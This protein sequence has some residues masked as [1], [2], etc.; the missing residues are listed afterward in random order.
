MKKAITDTNS[1]S[2]ESFYKI[3]IQDIIK[4]ETMFFN[5][6]VR[7]DLRHIDVFVTTLREVLEEIITLKIHERLSSK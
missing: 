1:W 6:E 4:I 5:T 7:S 3:P 2:F